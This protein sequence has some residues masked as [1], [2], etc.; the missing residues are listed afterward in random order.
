MVSHIPD[1]NIDPLSNFKNMSMHLPNE[2]F[3]FSEITFNEM[4]DVIDNLKN[5][6]SRDMFG[7]SVKLLK[8]IKNLII[9][10][11]TKLTNLSVCF[12]KN[13]KKVCC[14]SNF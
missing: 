14:N 7:L 10:P 4:R 8:I 5:K 6:S 12:S 3:V 13:P 11:L 1:S 2:N 9:I